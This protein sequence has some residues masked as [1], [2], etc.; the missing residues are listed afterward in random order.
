MTF[1]IEGIFK[2]TVV[3]SPL[4]M[5]DTFQD[6]QWMPVTTG[7][8]KPYILCFFPRIHTYDKVY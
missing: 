2:Y 4:P 6:P 5:G 3:P 1:P 8:T 7:S